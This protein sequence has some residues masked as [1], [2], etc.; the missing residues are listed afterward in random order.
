M[1]GTNYQSCLKPFE[2]EI[3]A[4]RGTK[5]PMP[6]SKIAE[7]LREK[8]QIEVCRQA[9]YRFLKT[10]AKGFKSCKLTECINQANA[11]NQ[12]ATEM[13]SVS[14]EPQTTVSAVKAVQ[15]EMTQP[16]V[17]QPAVKETEQ[18]VKSKSRDFEEIFQYSETYNLTR[19]SNEE[20]AER[21]KK[22]EER[23]KLKQKERIL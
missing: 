5:P 22:L 17:K 14:A 13:P 20:A 6:Y 11:A 23:K 10:L 12:P 19:L 16:V 7:Y 18:T 15:K 21:L 1:T 9:I 4:L 3:L 8:Y 2:K